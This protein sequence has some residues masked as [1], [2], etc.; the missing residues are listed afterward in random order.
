MRD[1]E[2]CQ[3]KNKCFFVQNKICLWMKIAEK[4]GRSTS[5]NGWRWQRVTM[6]L[7]DGVTRVLG[8]NAHIVQTYSP[9]WASAHVRHNHADGGG[10]GFNAIF[11]DLWEANA[12]VLIVCSSCN[13]SQSPTMYQCKWVCIL[14]W[15]FSLPHGRNDKHQKW[16]SKNACQ[17]VMLDGSTTDWVKRIRKTHWTLTQRGCGMWW[18]EWGRAKPRWKALM[19][20]NEAI[21]IQ[22]KRGEDSNVEG[23]STLTLMIACVRC[24][25]F[26]DVLNL[27]LLHI[28]D[29]NQDKERGRCWWD[30]WALSVSTNDRGITHGRWNKEGVEC[31]EELGVIEETRWGKVDVLGII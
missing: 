19:I 30:Q 16:K 22:V 2:M 12:C 21:H 18:Y 15:P 1:V 29:H 17:V 7:V 26:G 5:A 28:S 13:V 31:V 11:E 9:T 25:M 6:V 8:A 23:T 24:M 3:S 20:S 4:M 14:W 10:I 27:F